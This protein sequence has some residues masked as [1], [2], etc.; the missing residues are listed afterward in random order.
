MRHPRTLLL[1][2]LT[3]ALVVGPAA[4]AF[5]APATGVGGAPQAFTCTGTVTHAAPDG[6]TI[7]VL[8]ASLALTGALGG[9]LDLTVTGRSAL[10][11]VSHGKTTP[12]A[13]ADV[14]VG[15][16]L[17][18]Q[19]TIDAT[20]VPGTTLYDI[21]TACAWRPQVLSPFLCVGTVTWVCPQAGA[22]LLVVTVGCGSSGLGDPVGSSV[23]IDVPASA[24]IYVL[25]HR[26]A[27]TTT[28]DD[29]TSGDLVQIAGSADRTDAS[30]PLFT[31]TRVLAT[32]VTPL[33]KLTWF[34]LRG[35]VAGPGSAPGTLLVTLTCGTRAVRADVGA[36]LTLTTTS[37][38]LV[39]TLA[40]GIVTTVPLAQ[41][42][43]G[44]SIAVTGTIDI[45]VPAA[46]VHDIGHAFVWPTPAP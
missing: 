23:T 32:H 36:E 30:T 13:P 1:I 8:H 6:L 38:S 39:R 12:V 2:A 28:F 14:P 9:Q 17:S 45:R 5:G 42:A 4:R 33:A 26:L 37:S 34:S 3:A 15:D 11:L 22:H 16:L 25:H 35:V 44:D 20:S 19:G 31:A 10:T 43:P 24:G 41:I 29:L 21:G 40:D 18:V 7:T 27:T 46:P